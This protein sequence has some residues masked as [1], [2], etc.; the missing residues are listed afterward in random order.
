M[1]A[2]SSCAVRTYIILQLLKDPRITSPTIQQISLY[3]NHMILVYHLI[4]DNSLNGMFD[5]VVDGMLPCT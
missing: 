3:H 1:K 5:F 4:I 2:G